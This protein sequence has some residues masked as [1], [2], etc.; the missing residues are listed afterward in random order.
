MTPARFTRLCQQIAYTV[1]HDLNIRGAL[2]SA[3]QVACVAAGT[4]RTVS[5]PTISAIMAEL[6]RHKIKIPPPFKTHPMT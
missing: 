4:E 1:N 3:E 6:R 5:H 2:V